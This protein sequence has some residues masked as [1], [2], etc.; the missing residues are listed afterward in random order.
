MGL[1]PEY[2]KYRKKV[3]DKFVKRTIKNRKNKEKILLKRMESRKSEKEAIIE[4][5][6]GRKIIPEKR[7][8]P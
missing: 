1:G 5:I 7:G 6:K 2:V 8:R 4:E 3:L